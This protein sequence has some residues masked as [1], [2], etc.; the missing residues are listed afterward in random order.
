MDRRQFL[1]GTAALATGTIAKPAIAQGVTEVSFFYPI[2]VGGPITKLIDAFAADFEKENPSIK[3]KP[4]LCRHLPGDDRQGAHRT[5][6]RHAAGDL[7]AALDRHV[8]AHRRG[9]DRAD[10]RLPQ[11][12]RRQ[13]MAR[14]LL[15]RLHAQ[16]PDAR[17]GTRTWGVP[18]QR[19]TIVLYWNKE[20]FKEAGLDPEKATGYV[21]RA[22]RLRREADETR[23]RR[24][25]HAMGGAGALLRLSLLALPGLHHAGRRDPHEPGGRPHIL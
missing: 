7:G 4:D 18:F 25:R 15:P 1:A 2:A 22:G 19:S 11:D 20:L 12:R 13:E 3:V 9:R 10:R 5:Q 23:R 16:Q 6:E 24:Q 17:Q 8:H 14:E 21:G